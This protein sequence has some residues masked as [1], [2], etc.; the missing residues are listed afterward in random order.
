MYFRIAAVLLILAVSTD[1]I[2]P[3]PISCSC[4]TPYGSDIIVLCNGT[5]LSDI[6][7]NI[8]NDASAM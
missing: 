5:G 1:L 2:L 3:C 7:R 8:P 6:P 4:Y